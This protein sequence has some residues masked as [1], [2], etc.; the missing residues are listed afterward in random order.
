MI[1]LYDNLRKDKVGWGVFLIKGNNIECEVWSTSVGGGLPVGRGEGIIL[2]DTTFCI[3]KSINIR[4]GKEFPH[5]DI[6]HFRKFSPKPDS[7]NNFIP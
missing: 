1:A 7:T 6:Y 3:V 5:N 4:D 2:N